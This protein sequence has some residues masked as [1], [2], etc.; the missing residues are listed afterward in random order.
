MQTTKKNS[1]R[2]KILTLLRNQKEEDRTAKS[3]R[4]QKKL[5][6]SKEFKSSLTILFYTAFDG[7]VETLEMI[8]QAIKLGKRIAL[9]RIIK[10]T[11][12]LV[13]VLVRNLRRDLVQGPFGIKQPRSIKE[14]IID[15]RD[16]DMVVVP[17]VAFDKNNYRLGRGGGYYDRFLKTLSSS[18]SSIGLAFDFQIVRR[19]PKEDHDVCLHR[20]LVG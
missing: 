9:P 13:P 6:S 12:A 2:K 15:V 16:V 18:A 5:L 20:V 7:E 4:I 17:G 19:L 1:L 14:N 3:S 11:R 8:E 10:R